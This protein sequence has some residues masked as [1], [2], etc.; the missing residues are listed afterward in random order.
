MPC[1]MKIHFKFSC[2]NQECLMPALT[3]LAH[4]K[5]LKGNSSLQLS[6]QGLRTQNS[7]SKNI[8]R[9]ELSYMRGGREDMGSNGSSL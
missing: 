1:S 6:E 2:V 8:N 3:S 9:V 5:Q 7:V 4:P